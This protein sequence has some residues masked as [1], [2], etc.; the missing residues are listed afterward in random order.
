LTA[1]KKCAFALDCVGGD[2]G[3]MAVEGLGPGGRMLVYGA[4]SGEPIPLA[5]RV[6][7]GG[8]K[9]IAGF[10]LSEWVKT[11]GLLA[12]LGLFREIVQLLREDVLTSQIDATYPMEQFGPAVE[13][14]TRPGRTGKVLMRIEASHGA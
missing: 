12:M 10:W 2:M 11:Q 3:R 5:P 13:H 9:S 4:L 1:G 8:Q 14:A 7:M 6:L